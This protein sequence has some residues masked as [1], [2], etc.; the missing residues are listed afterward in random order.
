MIPSAKRK[1]LRRRQYMHRLSKDDRR[2]QAS[3]EACAISAAG[4]THGA[5]LRLA[6]VYLAQHDVDAA[7]QIMRDAINRFLGHHQ[8]DASKY[9][10]TLTRAWLMAVRHFM[11]R[12]G[13]TGCADDFLSKSAVLLDSN[14]MLTHYSKDVLFSAAARA[15]FVEP[16]LD[17]IPQHQPHKGMGAT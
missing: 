12:A 15:G 9:H 10:E 14:V 7:L 3:F 8:I 17:P 5:H 4:F 13:S 11:D 1:T 6:Y 2:F 16:D